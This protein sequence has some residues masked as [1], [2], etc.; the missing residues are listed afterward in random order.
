MT[1]QH[2]TPEELRKLYAEKKL[3]DAVARKGSNIRDITEGP[4]AAQLAHVF[5]QM[6]EN[7]IGRRHDS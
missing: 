2:F 5:R 4:L 3:R 1:D 6:E 7:G